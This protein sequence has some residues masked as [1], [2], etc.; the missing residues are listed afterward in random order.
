MLQVLLA[1][2]A[3]I[4]T[5]GSPCILPML[6]LLLGTSASRSPRSKA[7]RR[8]RPIFIV[9]GFIV[10]FAST[11]VVFGAT[12][13]VAGLSQ[14][15]L[16]NAGITV[17][18]ASGVL[19][20]SPMLLDRAM[21]P[22]GRLADLAQRLGNRAGAGYAGGLLLGLSLGLLWTPCAGPV[23]ASVLALIATDQQ[24]QHASSV[25]IAYSVGAGLPMLL[26]AYGGQAVTAKARGFSRIAGALRKVFG[27]M[28]IASAA[29]MY[30]QVDVAAVAWVSRL[31][32]SDV[33]ASTDNAT[34]F[35]VGIPAPEFSGID[36]WFNSAPLTMHSMKGKVV[37]IDFWTYDCINCANTLPY[38]KRWHEMFKDQ[39]LVVVG[40][41]TPEFPFERET[42]NLRRAIARWGIDYPVAQ[43]N[44]FKTWNAWSNEYWPAVYLVDRAGRVVF[45]HDGEGDY[46][47]IEKEI[48]TALDEAG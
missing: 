8:L 5:A 18:M 45:H 11:T 7:E 41:H 20:I 2:G 44:G 32:G 22:F 28:V 13:Q 12:T 9:L 14:Q 4:A 24:V 16:R 10:S 43:D 47:R 25:L 37:L 39:G 30:F 38:V 48:Q 46:E 34:H 3:G 6:P 33:E 35:S 29:A 42:E 23:L 40:V 17:L 26:I 27:A 21:A 36:N 15:T 1:L 31:F 19:L